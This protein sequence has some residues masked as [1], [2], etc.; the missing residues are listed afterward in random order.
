MIEMPRLDIEQ[1]H[2]LIEPL[3]DKGLGSALSPGADFSRMVEP[4]KGD[5]YLS[6]VKENIVF[7]TDEKGSEAASVVS[8]MIMTTSFRAPPRQINV[9]LN[10]SF[11]MAVQDVRT[12][13]VLFAGAVNKPNNEMKRAPTPS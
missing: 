5:V 1:E 2:D 12:G 10:R 9:E 11:V 4:G 3:T 8:G 13:A 7:K 6:K